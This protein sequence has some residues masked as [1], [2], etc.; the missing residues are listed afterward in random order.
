VWGTLNDTQNGER[1]VI[2]KMKTKMTAIFAILMIALMVAGISYAMWD[3][4][5]YLYGTVNTGEV[6]A[7]FSRIYCD[8]DGIDPGYDKDVASCECYIDGTDHQI[9][10]VE[11]DNGYP[12]YSVIVYFEIDNTGTV[13]VKIQNIILT[14]PNTEVTV[15]ITD[16]SIGQQIDPGDSVRGD[17]EIHIK[18]SAAENAQYTFSIEIF[19]VQWNEF[20]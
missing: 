9:A 10:Y 20:K 4:T 13:P 12:C 18:Q 16:I 3:K 2:K 7:E 6:D 14:N 17:L 11:I 5:I 15:V 8:D 1:R 19:L